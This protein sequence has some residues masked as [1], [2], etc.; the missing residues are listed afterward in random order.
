MI[1]RKSQLIFSVIFLWWKKKTKI[2]N[3]FEG[4]SEWT[5]RDKNAKTPNIHGEGET[6]HRPN[7]ALKHVFFIVSWNGINAIIVDMHQVCC[8]RAQTHDSQLQAEWNKMTAND[9]SQR[10]PFLK[11]RLLCPH[12]SSTDSNSSMISHFI[13]AITTDI[14]FFFS[15]PFC[16]CLAQCLLFFY[17]PLKMF[18]L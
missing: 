6:I 12:L 3:I 7:M 15:L 17:R 11:L 14:F 5:H 2:A 4:L 10:R 16:F 9:K 13:H 1:Q 8:R 18:I